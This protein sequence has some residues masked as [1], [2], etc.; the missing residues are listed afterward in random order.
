MC[1][2]KQEQEAALVFYKGFSQYMYEITQW[3][4][5]E[6]MHQYLMATLLLILAHV[7]ESVEHVEEK[8]SH[9]S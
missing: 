3:V 7:Y 4:M 9:T 2:F 6:I 8:V 5:L 1:M